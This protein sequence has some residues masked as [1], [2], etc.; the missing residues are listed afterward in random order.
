MRN[1]G[2]VAW[3]V[4]ILMVGGCSTAER[5]EQSSGSPSGEL[6]ATEAAELAPGVTAA[7]AS[8]FV[9][10]RIGSRILR[11]RPGLG[12]RGPFR[13]SELLRIPF[14]VG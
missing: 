3:V 11:P 5:P 9:R 8:V 14:A 13:A 6:G 10:A 4:G 7:V 12:S 2:A 1:R